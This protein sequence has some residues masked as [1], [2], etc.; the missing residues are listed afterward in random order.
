MNHP[1]E[2]LFASWNTLVQGMDDASFHE[3]W[4]RRLI[5]GAPGAA[6]AVLVL[7]SGEQGTYAPVAVW[8][9]AQPCSA[10]LAT[11]CE[12]VMDL[13]LPFAGRVNG[14]V[15]QAQPV[16]LGDHL[17]GVAALGYASAQM[18]PGVREWMSWG[19]GWLLVRV[20][21]T[22]TGTSGT[23]QD[24]LAHT[25]DLIMAA[26]EEP[27]ATAAAQALVT[28]ASVRLGCDRVSVGFGQ[29]ALVHFAALSHSADVAR[30][31]DLVRAL[32]AAMNEASEQGMCL[33]WPLV[34]SSAASAGAFVSL[35]EHER[36]SR[37]FGSGTLLSVPFAMDE[38]RQGVFL[39][40]WASDAPPVGVCE[41]AE[42]MA[43]LLGRVLLEKR[44]AE[45]SVPVRLKDAWLEEVQKIVGPRHAIRKVVALSV[46]G[47][48]GIFSVVDGEHRVSAAAT[49]EGSVRRQITAPFDGFVAT[50]VT[51]AG[52][53]VK[54][55]E[56][57]ATLDDRD[58]KLETRRWESQQEQF[59]RQAQDA[60]AQSNLAQIQIAMAQ[61]RQAQAQ[62][63]LSEAQL[64]RARVVAPF[65]GV[66][67]SG[68]LSQSLGAAVRKGQTLFEIAPLDSYRI[69]LEVPEVDF[70]W[71]RVGQKGQLVLT[72]LTGETLPFTVS[73][74]T[75]VA[76]AKD[77]KNVFRVEATPDRA[78]SRLRPG[79]EGVAKVEIGQRRLIWIWTHSM[80]DWLR[81]QSWSWLGL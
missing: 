24:R 7:A 45:R 66:V 50:A 11:A 16:M 29:E 78:M 10:E 53:T 36:L 80:L 33:R 48:I 8:P 62:K 81:L 38:R 5:D 52:Q 12:R 74:V 70:A 34:A 72:A 65:D 59:T 31:I 28:E 63:D 44:H 13:R 1:A 57:L 27:N 21:S 76:A 2:R 69:V 79:M 18:P 67:V 42:A 51:R 71:V 39:F 40:E 19:L 55:D 9:Q 56:V 47:L 61:T 25:L 41:Q 35:R 14:R 32:E 68:D 46:L 15:V 77:G 75:P 60:E 17:L 4:L 43:P 20:A 30:R 22:T 54:A 26:V 6:E 58:M 37:D 23:L 49:L 64:A 73:L 3:A